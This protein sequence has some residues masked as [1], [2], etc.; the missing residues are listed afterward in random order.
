M[1]PWTGCR[2]KM[3][4]SVY[5]WWWMGLVFLQLDW[6]QRVK[7]R[8]LEE[9]KPASCVIVPPHPPSPQHV[10][11]LENKLRR[12]AVGSSRAE[13]PPRGRCIWQA[14]SKMPIW[15]F[16]VRS[17]TKTPGI[18][19][20]AHLCLAN[21]KGSLVVSRRVR[22]KQGIATR[23]AG[24]RCPARGAWLLHPAW[25]PHTWQWDVEV[26][27]GGGAST[28]LGRAGVGSLIPVFVCFHVWPPLCLWLMCPSS[29]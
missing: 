27:I 12:Q 10:A 21:F 14:C 24:Q 1:S 9:S 17:V 15:W 11:L 8:D 20:R 6:E 5:L 29:K 3:W 18:L 25:E 19:W 28:P 4:F 7:L 13:L 23:R 26:W 2:Y 22:G 16:T